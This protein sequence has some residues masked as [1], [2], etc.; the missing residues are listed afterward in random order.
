MPELPEVETIRLGLNKLI[1][2]AV[3]TNV[4]VYWNRMITPPFSSDKFKQVLKG[5]KIHT[6]ERRGKYLIFILDHWAMVSHLRMEGKYEVVAK[7]DEYKKHTH[8]VFHLADGRDLRYMDVRKFGR[9]TLL[10]IDKQNEFEPFKKLGPEPRPENFNVTHFHE[11]LS[12]TKRAIKPV[13]L[14]QTVVAGVGNIYADES[15]FLAKINPQK[16]AN[17]LNKEETIALHAAIIDVIQHAVERGGST[18]RSYVN[19]LGEAGS[20]QQELNVYGRTG[21]PCQR[22]GTPIKKIKLAQRGTHFCPNCQS[23]LI[24]EIEEESGK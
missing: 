21:E 4:D 13:I 1:S 15:L 24:E 3:I 17:T 23:F 9:F 14:D 6:V 16:P 10:P 12:K 19:T 22:C 8:V 7:N 18:I 11:K 5:E 2:K 20:F